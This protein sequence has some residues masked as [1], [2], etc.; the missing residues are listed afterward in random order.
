MFTRKLPELI[1]PLSTTDCKNKCNSVILCFHFN[2]WFYSAK[3]L[4]KNGAL[5]LL[6]CYTH[7]YTDLLRDTL[8]QFLFLWIASFLKLPWLWLKHSGIQVPFR[9]SVGCCGQK[10]CGCIKVEFLQ[11][12]YGFQGLRGPVIP[13]KPTRTAKG[14]PGDADF[15]W[16]HTHLA[17]T[18]SYIGLFCLSAFFFLSLTIFQLYYPSG[19]AQLWKS[20]LP[21]SFWLFLPRQL[22]ISKYNVISSYA[23]VSGAKESEDNKMRLHV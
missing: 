15:W 21:H 6:H 3:W 13:N 10:Q 22:L 12:Y 17:G 7:R 4:C 16:H 20:E 8:I 14:Q 23:K 19:T 9:D 2:T 18:V 1:N 11:S 5:A